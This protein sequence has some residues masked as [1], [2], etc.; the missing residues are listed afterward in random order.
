MARLFY[1]DKGTHDWTDAASLTFIRPRTDLLTTPRNQRDLYFRIPSA[2]I[3]GGK[4]HIAVFGTLA[5]ANAF[6]YFSGGTGDPSDFLGDSDWRDANGVLAFLVDVTWPAAPQTLSPANVAANAPDLSG[7]KIE[8]TGD[9][10]APATDHNM[11]VGWM[12]APE[13]LVQQK[14]RQTLEAY[15]GAGQALADFSSVRLEMV[16]A[17]VL[18]RSKAPNIVGILTVTEAE[19][20]AATFLAVKVNFSIVVGAARKGDEEVAEDVMT[21]AGSIRSIL[22]TESTLDGVALETV[23]ETTDGP[24]KAEN[25]AKELYAIA[26]INGFARF[27]TLT[28]EVV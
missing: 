19:T 3:G 11:V 26:T 15:M 22:E 7:L 13:V 12:A 17:G 9:G 28:R 14:L 4:L 6:D 8:I 23:I 25:D 5:E 16:P 1:F 20:A 24:S 27:P 21:Y 10:S 18:I 2:A